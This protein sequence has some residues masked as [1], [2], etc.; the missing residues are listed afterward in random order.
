MPPDEEPTVRTAAAVTLTLALALSACSGDDATDPG[1]AT[2]E[3]ATDAPAPTGADEASGATESAQAGSLT[4]V[5][6]DQLAWEETSKTATPGT[7]E[8]TIECGDTVNHALAIEGVQ[9]GGD[10]AACDPG[11]SG[12]TTVE[13]EAGEYTYF[14]TVPGHREAGMEGTL[15]VSG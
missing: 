8:V 6:T 5:G 3:A 1:D 4:F 9:G 15:T 13:L 7:I 11:G 14:C 12:S 10:L 2:T